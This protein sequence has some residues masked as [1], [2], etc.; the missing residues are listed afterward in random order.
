MG[1]KLNA[2]FIHILERVN[3]IADEN[4]TWISFLINNDDKSSANPNLFT[5]VYRASS[6]SSV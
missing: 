5:I 6:C 4:S 3:Q 1:F 2:R